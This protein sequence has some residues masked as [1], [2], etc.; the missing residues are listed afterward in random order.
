[1]SLDLQWHWSITIKNNTKALCS[2]TA[3]INETNLSWILVVAGYKKHKKDNNNLFGFNILIPYIKPFVNITFF[4][5]VI[6]W[7]LQ[8]MTMFYN[9]QVIINI[10][11]FAFLEVACVLWFSCMLHM[12]SW[13]KLVS[14]YYSNV[15]NST[16][17]DSWHLDD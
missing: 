8:K 4:A 10:I 14:H 11:D 1:M 12:T 13:K 15:I 2:L 17:K 16:I 3:N 6:E 5:K 7:L 9:W